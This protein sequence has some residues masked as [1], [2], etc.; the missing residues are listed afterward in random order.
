MA[1]FACC[2]SWRGRCHRSGTPVQGRGEVLPN[3]NRVSSPAV[4]WG[5]FCATQSQVWLLMSSP[6]ALSWNALFCVFPAVLLQ[7]LAPS[8]AAGTAARGRPAED[9]LATEPARGSCRTGVLR[10]PSPGQGLSCACP[11]ALPSLASAILASASTAPSPQCVQYRGCH[12]HSSASS[13]L[14]SAVRVH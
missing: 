7:A 2:P 12:K 11:P 9:V 10:V 13:K 4:C 5:L 6:N 3:G 1:T 14:H 8:P